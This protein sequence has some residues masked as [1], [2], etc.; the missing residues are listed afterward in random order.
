MKRNDPFGVLVEMPVVFDQKRRMALL[1]RSDL[2]RGGGWGYGS[3]SARP[4]DFM[5]PLHVAGATVPRESG[6]EPHGFSPP[7]GI[8]LPV[9]SAAS[10]S[11]SR[12]RRR[13]QRSG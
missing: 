5:T 6:F 3:T 1:M 13:I 4:G 11:S 8:E 9:L 12:L 10:C 2:R 7:A